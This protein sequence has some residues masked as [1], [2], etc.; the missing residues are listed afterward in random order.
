VEFSADF[1]AL[2]CPYKIYLDRYDVPN[3][4]R[5]GLFFILKRSSY[6]NFNKKFVLSVFKI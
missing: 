4:V 3:R 5:S 2:P 6:L 1:S